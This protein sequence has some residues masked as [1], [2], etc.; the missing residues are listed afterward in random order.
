MVEGCNPLAEPVG[1]AADRYG[2]VVG[3]HFLQY[4]AGGGGLIPDGP[5]RGADLQS[6]TDYP[7]E[8]TANALLSEGSQG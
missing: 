3:H 2:Q 6:R 7:E 8:P 1:G 4:T 5:S